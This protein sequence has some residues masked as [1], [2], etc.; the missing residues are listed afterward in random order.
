MIQTL[1]K[2]RQNGNTKSYK[3]VSD[4]FNISTIAAKLLLSR[5]YKKFKDIKKYL[6]PTINELYDPYIFNAME[7][8]VSRINTAIEQEESIWIF[9]DYDVDGITSTSILI[10]YFESIGVNV[11]YYIPNRQEE[12]YG[13]NVDAI[14]SIFNEQGKLIITV[15]CGIT[16]Y[17]PVKRCNALGMDI[18]ITDHHKCGE[19][20]PEAYGILNPKVEEE[21]Y[22]YDMLAGVGL[23]FKLIQAH[24]Q[25][26][27]DAIYKEYIDLVAFGTIADIAPLTDE[28]RI[29]T[30][31]GLEVINHTPNPGIKALMEVSEIA[32][33][34]VTG[35]KIGYI[36]APKINAAG[37]LG[38]PKLGV[39]LLTSTDQER[40]REIANTLKNLNEQRQMIE[41]AIIIKAE[42]TIDQDVSYTDEPV[43]VVYGKTWHSGVI[44]IVASR[45]VEKYNKPAIVLTKDDG[46]VRGSARSI[47]ELNIHKVIK[48]CD[49]L[50]D[51]FGGHKMAAGVTLQVENVQAF[52]REINAYVRE[53][54]SA[55]ALQPVLR[56]DYELDIESVSVD[57]I[58]AMSVLEPFGVGNPKPKFLLSQTQM[59]DLR[60]VGKDDSHLKLL[61]KKSDA[62]IDGIGF[63]LGHIKSELE[64]TVDLIFALDVNEYK[65]F[66]SAQLIIDDIKNSVSNQQA[67]TDEQPIDKQYKA[68]AYKA[69]YQSLYKSLKENCTYY[70]A[71]D[72]SMQFQAEE[73]Q[74]KKGERVLVLL[75][76]FKTIDNGLIEKF[77][78]WNYSYNYIKEPTEKDILINPVL[79]SI[80]VKQYDKI[81]FWD[82]PIRNNNSNLNLY[83]LVTEK[84]LNE[85]MRLF[86]QIPVRGVLV[87][88]Y[89]H[90]RSNP[91][92]LLKKIQKAL[93][94][95]LSTFF[96]A[97]GLLEELQLISYTIEENSVVVEL[98]PQ[99]KNKIKLENNKSYNKLL[100]LRKIGE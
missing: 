4:K 56:Y 34:D 46:V 47:G 72:F 37:R 100:E 84:K 1:W 59:L 22:P 32:L 96:I 98:L 39:E 23:A 9:G 17:E 82:I 10:K 45:L 36:L 76:S 99:P 90:V 94:C 29:I 51:N 73:F 38:N 69:Y 71:I 62:T 33:G 35:G 81:Y 97:M 11:K 79:R 14:E 88:I 40:I 13:L 42:Q 16:S 5:G 19:A 57:T 55:T 53:N 50:L 52:R 64:K 70:K 28:N 66:K 86:N 61:L 87:R 95:S 58:E 67:K 83:S 75:S 91:K 6:E 20:L 49:E 92:L 68:E 54:V 15:D 63:N 30:K 44:G 27:F 41:K 93:K 80:N 25:E 31:L 2:T 60:T 12:G 21:Q 89:K 65:G 18:I 74:V 78:H 3:S 77:K 43:L 85:L 24:S 26:S 48:S 8:I 7:K